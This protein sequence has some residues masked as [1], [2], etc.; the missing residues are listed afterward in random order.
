[1][2]A[3]EWPGQ[4]TAVDWRNA[5]I[6]TAEEICVKAQAEDCA[7]ARAGYRQALL[8]LALAASYAGADGARLHITELVNKVV[9]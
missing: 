7:V 8:S 1:M 4:I 2:S 6:R 9:L 3:Q 5:V